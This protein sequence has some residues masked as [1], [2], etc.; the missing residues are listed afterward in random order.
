ML[1]FFNHCLSDELNCP[2]L[3]SFSYPSIFILQVSNSHFYLT[4]FTTSLSIDYRLTT[5]NRLSHR[6][7][8]FDFSLRL[9]QLYLHSCS[10]SLN[11]DY[12]CSLLSSQLMATSTMG[13]NSEFNSSKSDN[14]STHFRPLVNSKFN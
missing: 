4:I 5:D 10:N 9:V 13:D 11:H 12:L 7:Q 14:S 6:S 1:L 2:L 8:Q 3:H